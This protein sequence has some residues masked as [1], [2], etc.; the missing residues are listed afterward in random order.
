LKDKVKDEPDEGP[1]VATIL[2]KNPIGNGRMQRR[3]R[4]DDTIDVRIPDLRTCI[5]I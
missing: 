4:K 1:E 3:F 2:F 5:I